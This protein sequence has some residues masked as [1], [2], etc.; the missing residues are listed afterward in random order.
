M[1]HQQS[2]IN[3]ILIIGLL[4][5]LYAP[6]ILHWYDGWLEKSISIEHE[7]FSH[8]LIGLPY[9][10]YLSWLK[11]KKWQ[12]LEN[13]IHPLGGI[14]LGWGAIS[15]LTGVAEWVNLS[16]PLILTGLCL[17]LKGIEG[18]KLQGF[19]L[20]LV[21]L[22]TPNSL[23]Y[24]IIPYTLPLQQLIA[25]VAGFILL[26]L[27][28]DVQVEQI[29]ITV[30]GR[31]VEV[32]PYCAGLKMLFTSLY[33]ALML[34][35]WTGNISNKN[36]VL[37]LLVGAVGIS[38]IGNILRNTI[39]TIFFGNHQ[40]DLFDWLHN[41]WG[42]DVYSA[43]MLGAILLLYLTMERYYAARDEEDII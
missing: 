1:N 33:V 3:N 4:G 23:P 6:L 18:L 10:L 7:Y 40:D 41:G 19:S 14:L 27:G 26:Q 11:R 12:R 5:I 20:I 28:F 32:A 42:G 22:A 13:K 8:G 30:G 2:T 9:A 25:G 21:W 36:K 37:W 31:L 34:L 17:W 43:G 24:L 16:F 38:I 35:Y 15:Y 29:Y 39:L